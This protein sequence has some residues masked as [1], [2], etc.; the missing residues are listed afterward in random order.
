[1]TAIEKKQYEIIKFGES[2]HFKAVASSAEVAEWVE[3]QMYESS[4]GFRPMVEMDEDDDVLFLHSSNEEELS[5]DEIRELT[6]IGIN[7]RDAHE[8]QHQAILE[9]LGVSIHQVIS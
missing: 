9:Y 3:E 6:S 1:M 8:K 2:L 4:L 5:E 7:I